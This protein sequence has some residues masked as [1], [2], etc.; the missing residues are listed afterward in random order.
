MVMVLVGD[1]I[2]A[3]FCAKNVKKIDLS[4]KNKYGENVTS[5]CYKLQYY[6]LLSIF[7]NNPTFDYNYRDINYNNNLLIISSIGS[8]IMVNRILENDINLIN[9]MNSR[10][11]NALIVASKINNTGAVN[12]LLDHGIDVNC[13]D[14]KGNTALHYAVEIEKPELIKS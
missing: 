8:P 4:M 1:G 3:S 7:E 5:L 10:G 12:T 6:G 2:T 11:E 13:K 9:E 14:E